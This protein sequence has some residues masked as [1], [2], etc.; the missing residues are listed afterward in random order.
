MFSMFEDFLRLDMRKWIQLL[1]NL[2]LL[3]RIFGQDWSMVFLQNFTGKVTIVPHF[4]LGD[5][6]HTISDPDAV[7]MRHYIE[8][9][10]KNTWPKISMITNRL[11]V[12]QTI[13]RMRERFPT[14][15]NSDVSQS[16]SV[17]DL[18]PAVFENAD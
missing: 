9:G 14:H 6:F 10:E 12:E 17:L 11:K 16:S 4:R 5:Y 18:P 8:G 15:T 13:E 3:P 1:H 2:N 7:G